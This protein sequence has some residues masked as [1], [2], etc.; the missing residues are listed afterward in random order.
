M[1]QGADSAEEKIF[2]YSRKIVALAPIALLAQ[3]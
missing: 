1:P 3:G 2:S